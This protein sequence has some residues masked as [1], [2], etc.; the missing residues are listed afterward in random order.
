[1]A[2]VSVTTRMLHRASR[3]TAVIVVIAAARLAAAQGAKGAKIPKEFQPPKDGVAIVRK[4]RGLP[5]TYASC[6]VTYAWTRRQLDG[7]VVTSGEDHRDLDSGRVY[8]LDISLTGMLLGETR[9]YW[10]PQDILDVTV[11]E[12]RCPSLPDGMWI[13]PGAVIQK[14][15]AGE[16]EIGGPSGGGYPIVKSV[17]LRGSAVVVD[18]M[19]SES[20]MEW[21]QQ[22]PMTQIEARLA[23]AQAQAHRKAGR[24][25][26]A[27]RELRRALALEPTLS[28]AA[29]ELAELLLAAGRQ[30]EAAAVVADAART[31]PVWLYRQ[32]LDRQVLAPLE[33]LPAIR[34]ARATPGDVHWSDDF[35][36]AY[37]RATDTFAVRQSTDFD[38]NGGGTWVDFIGPD[39]RLQASVNLVSCQGMD[40][41]LDTR[42]V[43]LVNRMLADLGFTRGADGEK[44]E[45]QT[46]ACKFRFPSVHVGVVCGKDHVRVVQRDTVLVEAALQGYRYTFAVR[47]PGV[48]ALGTWTDG[49]GHQTITGLQVL[50]SPAIP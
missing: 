36:V 7:K 35:T 5:V 44:V 40:C 13:A 10:R 15:L 26:D 43:E 27:M 21:T 16:L 8:D 32:I 39:D 33:A 25:A 18:Y 11:R 3:V 50:R 9:R 23:H 22:Y 14:G 1:M 30:D 4:G 48:V 6:A 37:S 47:F 24:S 41:P 19:M 42:G 28:T 45:D 20:L 38:G 46:L 34:A 49:Y 12:A 17:K 29:V 2:A 31:R